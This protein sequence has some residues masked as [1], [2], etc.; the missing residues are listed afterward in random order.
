MKRFA[1][2]V[3]LL[4]AAP[5]WAA[6]LPAQLRGSATLEG[7]SIRLGD[8]WDNLAEAKVA[9]VIAPAPQ[10][11]KRVTLDARWLAAVALNNGVDW[12]PNGNFDRIVVERAG[13]TVPVQVIENEI[14]EAL[15][16][17]GLPQGSGIEI[18]N[19]SALAVVVPTGV[20]ATVA[21]RDLVLDPRT[22]RFSA[23]VEV[24]AGSPAATRLRV[25]GRTFTMSRVPVLARPVSRGDVIAERDIQWIEIRDEGVRRDL[26][27]DPRE[28]VGKEP[29]FQLKA[30][31]PIR[32]AELQR[33]LVVSR[34]AQVMLVLKTPFMTLTAQG[35]ALD[36]GG[37][38]DVVKV[39][40]LQ[41]KQTVEGIVEGPNTVSI[42]AASARTLT[43]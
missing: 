42:A 35:R 23:T 36:D 14:K 18:N 39:T 37:R 11:G 22:Q 20:Q 5:A 2:A 3:A 10:A 41:T 16:M 43:N 30:G 33:P 1:V 21:V 6:S 24:P 4:L 32:L 26:A 7:D 19:R 40:N 25:S 12:R 8:L 28:I 13:Q 29:R 31:Q 34:N 9:T 15:D 38:G 17:E 27:I